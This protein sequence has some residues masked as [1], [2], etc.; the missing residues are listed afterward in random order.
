MKTITGEAYDNFRKLFTNKKEDCS[1]PSKYITPS[2]LQCPVSVAFKLQGVVPSPEYKSIQDE[3]YTTSGES[4]HKTIQH[5]LVNQ[6]EIEWVDI[7]QY[8]KEHNLPFDVSYDYD[9]KQLSQKYNV[10]VNEACKILDSYEKVLTHRNGLIKFKLDGLIKYRN[11]YYIVEIKTVG[12]SKFKK[13]PL[14]EHQAQGICYSML[15]NISKIIW[16]YED[17]S[18]FDHIIVFQECTEQEQ[19]NMNNYLN[20]IVCNKDTPEKLQRNTNCCNTCRYKSYCRE[21][22]NKHS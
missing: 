1:I 3:G 6:P 14:V 8:V 9:V 16:I 22:F 4:R 17:R 18:Y 19:D 2:G 7:E 21:Y 15:M 10:P 11:E 5:F 13:A 12:T 20:M